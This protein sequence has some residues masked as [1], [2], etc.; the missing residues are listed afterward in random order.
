LAGVAPDATY[1]FFVRPDIRDGGAMQLAPFR[2]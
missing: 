2:A 1:L